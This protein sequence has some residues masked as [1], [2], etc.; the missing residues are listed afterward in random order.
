VWLTDQ[1]YSST[2]GLFLT[3]KAKGI[4]TTGIA[5][6]FFM[7]KRATKAPIAKQSEPLAKT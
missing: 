4:P 6:G 7:L 3:A 5:G 1:H 2:G